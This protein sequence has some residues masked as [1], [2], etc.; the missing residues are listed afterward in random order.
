MRLYNIPGNRI[1]SGSE[2]FEL[3]QTN[4]VSLEI[5]AML[6][7]QKK[8]VID[9]TEFVERAVK[10]GWDR[11]RTI[12]RCRQACKDAGYNDKLMGQIERQG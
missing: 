9:W 12:R 1:I 7:A 11:N 5:S 6:A 4:G 10:S 2:I 8:M 3:H